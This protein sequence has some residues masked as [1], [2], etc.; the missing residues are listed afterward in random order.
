MILVKTKEKYGNCNRCTRRKQS[1]LFDLF[2]VFEQ[3]EISTNRIFFSEKSAISLNA[4]ATCSELPSNKN[5][6]K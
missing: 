4:C 1:M 3:M 2:K 5:T 6:I